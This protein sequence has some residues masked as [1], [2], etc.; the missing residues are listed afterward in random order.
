M[1]KKKGEPPTARWL[2]DA[3]TS[4]CPS[5][6]SINHGNKDHPADRTHLSDW[7]WTFHPILMEPEIFEPRGDGSGLFDHY[8]WELSVFVKQGWLDREPTV[9][10]APDLTKGPLGHGLELTLSETKKLQK[11]LYRALEIASGNDIANRR[12]QLEIADRAS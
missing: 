7:E 2:Q 9:A 12:Q 8:K 1:S 11:A 5:W 6:C 4:P 10:I 3:A